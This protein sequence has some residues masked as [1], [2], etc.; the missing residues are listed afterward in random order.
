MVHHDYRRFLLV[1]YPAQSHI[2]PALQ[3]AKRLISM[4]AHVTLLITL[5]MYRHMPNKPSIPGLS[6]LT[7]SDGYDAGFSVFTGGDE[8][9]RL[10]A[11]ELKR[12]GSEDLI[13]LTI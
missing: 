2:N 9:Y 3:L 5:H 6:L 11:S 8:D 7:F 4:G 1:I 12:R 13:V 10:Y